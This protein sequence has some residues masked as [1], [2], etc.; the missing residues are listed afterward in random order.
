MAPVEQFGPCLRRHPLCR[1]RR[2]HR[3]P[4]PVAPAVVPVVGAWTAVRLEHLMVTA[5]C[6]HLVVARGVSACRPP[7]AGVGNRQRRVAARYLA[8]PW[9]TGMGSGGG[10]LRSCAC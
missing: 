3:R 10:T 6:H 1:R 5:A 8:S 7:H 9:L 2:L 4:P